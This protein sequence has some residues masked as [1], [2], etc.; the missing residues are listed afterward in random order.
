MKSNEC[1]FKQAHHIPIYEFPLINEFGNKGLMMASAAALAGLYDS[2]CEIPPYEEELI[3]FLYRPS[4]VAA[5]GPQTMDI[6]VEHYTNFWKKA[7]ERVSSYPDALLFSTM[8]AGA[9]HPRVVEL[10]CKLAQ[11]PLK[12]GY[13]MAGKKCLD[14]MIL[15]ILGVTLLSRL[16]TIVLFAVDCNYAFKHIRRKMM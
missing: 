14:V 7:N 15:K 12:A 3:E 11:I 16:R 10:E 5:L 13:A 8:K 4:A 1:K 6:S 9:H 2:N